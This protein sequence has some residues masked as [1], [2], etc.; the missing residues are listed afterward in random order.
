MD[1]PV[2][3][4]SDV[5]TE[6]PAP[7]VS[8]D[9]HA[10]EFAD[11]GPGSGAATPEPARAEPATTATPGDLAQPGGK[12]DG[13]EFRHVEAAPQ[14]V[15]HLLKYHYLPYW[16]SNVDRVFATIDCRTGQI[17]A[18]CVYA[19]PV[20]RCLLRESVFGRLTPEVLNRDF[21]QLVRWM[22]MPSFRTLGVGTAL[23]RWSLSRVP[24]PV[25]EAINRSWVPDQP[26]RDVGMI[27]RTD[28]KRHY[29]FR[30][31]TVRCRDDE[32]A[33]PPE[34]SAPT[35]TA[36]TPGAQ[37]ACAAPAPVDA[38]PAPCAA[39]ACVGATPAPVAAPAPAE[40]PPALTQGFYAPSD[41][42]IRDAAEGGESAR[43]G[44]AGPPAYPRFWTNVAQLPRQTK[45]AL[46]QLAPGGVIRVYSW[47]AG[48]FTTY[49]D[50]R[51]TV[52]GIEGSVALREVTRDLEC[53]RRMALEIQAAMS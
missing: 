24:Q 39:P 27:A 22:V 49:E 37:A 15:R 33:L 40:A 12:P 3:V 8:D 41:A 30:L 1:T 52:A 11:E 35:G 2:S 18:A 23:L 13:R 42:E 25:V 4:I 47:N 19:F 44:P 48:S 34:G 45:L 29:Y 31:K 9:P 28:G 17:V 5:P 26:F 14:L 20:L 10:G 32:V 46:V 51:L 53:L 36:T 7:S 50:E 6:A 38:L 21:R 43:G 16:P